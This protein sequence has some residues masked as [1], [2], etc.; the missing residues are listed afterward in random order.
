MAKLQDV[1]SLDTF[2]GLWFYLKVHL[3]KEKHVPKKNSTLIWGASWYSWLNGVQRFH[4]SSA[5]DKTKKRWSC[6]WGVQKED[7]FV[8]LEKCW[9]LMRCFGYKLNCW[10]IDLQYKMLFFPPPWCVSSVWV[11]FAL[12]Y[13]IYMT[14]KL[15]TIQV[16]HLLPRGVLSTYPTPSPHWRLPFFLGS[17][18]EQLGWQQLQFA[19]GGCASAFEFFWSLGHG[20]WHGGVCL[21]NMPKNNNLL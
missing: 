21:G 4:L 11:C 10:E 16:L 7:G 3:P 18:A 19:N 8:W 12:V 2:C 14:F 17:Q 15:H 6:R 9:H 1:L 13:S 20:W 5:C